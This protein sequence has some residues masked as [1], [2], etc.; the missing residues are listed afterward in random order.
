MMALLAGGRRLPIW[1]WAGLL[2]GL[3]ALLVL[4]GVVRWHEGRLRIARAEGAAVQAELD[5]A[6]FEAAG[7]TATAAQRALVDTIAARAA[8]ISKETDDELARDHADL[9]R[10]YDALR[11]RWAEARAPE[12]GAG[13]GGTAAL[14]WPAGTADDAACAARGW[15][16][17]NVASAAA[18][19][20]DEAIAKDDAW[21]GWAATQAAGWPE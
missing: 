5:R 9:A 17:F 6:A 11:L 2:A 12:G 8:E 14:S 16:D 15:V 18:Q 4:W 10:R 19:A 20:A 3:A 21:I 13:A 1:L 7:A